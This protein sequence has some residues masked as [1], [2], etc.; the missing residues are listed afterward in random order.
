M[1]AA[2]EMEIQS[3]KD[4]R[5]PTDGYLITCQMKMMDSEGKEVQVRV[6][7]TALTWLL[8]K[9]DAQG[10]S[11]EELQKLQDGAIADISNKVLSQMNGVGQPI[12]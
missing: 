9:L 5:I 12:M 1:Q 2:I 10:S 4:G 6:P 8:E 3:A 7:Y 11:M